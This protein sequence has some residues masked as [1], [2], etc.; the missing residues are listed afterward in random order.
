MALAF[1]FFY[2]LIAN[3]VLVD[4]FLL[5]SC[6][7]INLLQLNETLTKNKKHENKT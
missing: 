2:F 1:R 6:F 5:T 7:E 4:L 3:P